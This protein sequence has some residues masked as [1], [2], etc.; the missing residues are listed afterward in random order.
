MQTVQNIL[1]NENES[2]YR[3][4]KYSLENNDPANYLF[5]N[6]IV[7]HDGDFDRNSKIW[8]DRF[9][10]QVCYEDQRK[11]YSIWRKSRINMKPNVI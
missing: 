5:V 9:K 3:L 2:K 10:A 1:Q 11:D 7:G 4:F 6:N 8:K